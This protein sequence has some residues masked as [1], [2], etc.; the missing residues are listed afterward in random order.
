MC[1][2]KNNLLGLKKPC[3]T[4]FERPQ[5]NNNNFIKICTLVEKINVTY[6]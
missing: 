3:K 1:T 6:K 4:F 5:I 2:F